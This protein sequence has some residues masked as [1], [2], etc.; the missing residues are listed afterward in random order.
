MSVS[1]KLDGTIGASDT[2]R[3]PARRGSVRIADQIVSVLRRH[4]IDRVF[5]IPGGT[6]S[7]LFDALIDT[8]IEVIGCQHET[9]AVYAAAGYAR[10]TGRPGVVLVTSGPGVLNAMTGIAAANLDE[11]PVVVLA[12]EVGTASAGRGA[13]QDGGPAG[14]DIETM[15]RPITKS[16]QSLW[17]STRAPASIEH[18]LRVANTSPKGAALVRLPV[19]LTQINGASPLIEAAQPARIPPDASTCRVIAQALSRARRPAIM[20]GVGGREP[21]V[22]DRLLALAEWLRCPVFTDIEGKGAFPESHPLHLGIFG[23]G[24]SGGISNYLAERPDVLVTVGCRLDDTTTLAYSDAISPSEMLIQLD[25][26]Q[27]RLCRSY[28]AD[29]ALECDL[30]ATLAEI[31]AQCPMPDMPTILRRDTAVRAASAGVNTAHPQ[32]QSAPHHPAAVVRALQHLLP[33]DAVFTSD[34][35]NHLVFAAQNLV[36]DRADGF[37]AGIGL[38]GMGSGIGNAIGLQM[39][40]GHRRRVV[41]ICGDGGLA[42]VGNELATCVE[43]GLPLTLAVMNDGRWGMVEDGMR[44]LY[45]RSP[46][47][48]IPTIDVVQWAE[49]MGARGHRIQSGDDLGR[50]LAEPHESPLVLD[51]PIDIAAKADNPR[52]QACSAEDRDA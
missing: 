21:G 2:T 24:A 7:P 6:I 49:S 10:V 5:G 23:V 29:I 47:W 26:A 11:A 18:A 15:F 9:M 8:D 42:M 17:T 45:G 20:V 28:P 32:L 51:F 12:G 50:L 22:S 16:A 4:G 52:V 41:A 27:Q 43:L 33:D 36:I 31:T 13:L 34:I 3:A 1:P 37:F 44:S 39:A 46:S 25:Y 14:L 35:G 19:D 40:Y 30:D 38:G 48:S